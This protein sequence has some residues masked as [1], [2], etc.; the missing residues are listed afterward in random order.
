MNQAIEI[1]ENLNEAQAASLLKQLH[2][3]IF[4]AIPYSEVLNAIESSGKIQTLKDVEPEI[5]KKTLDA[6]T[7]IGMAKDILTIFS[8][9]KDLSPILVSAWDKIKD[10]DNLFIGAV[11]SVGLVVNLTLFMVSSEIDYS[12]GKLSIKKRQV[13]A[14]VLK[15]IIEPVTALI[16]KIPSLS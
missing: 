2:Q 5:K 4:Q 13:N 6:D 12:D 9:D 15:A 16:K 7:S 3:D 14:D 1:V 8:R 10:Q 11:L